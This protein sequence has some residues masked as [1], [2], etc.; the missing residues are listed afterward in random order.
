MTLHRCP[1]CR[2]GFVDLA[3]GDETCDICGHGV[4]DEPEPTERPLYFTKLRTDDEP[5][6]VG[7]SDPYAGPIELDFRA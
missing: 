1:T 3:I 5:W 7:A 2:E 6:F 4:L